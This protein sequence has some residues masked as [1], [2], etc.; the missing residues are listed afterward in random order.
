MR[1][2]TVALDDA[3]FNRLI[4]YVV[5]NSKRKGSRLSVSRSA[6]ELISNG[7][8]NLSQRQEFEAR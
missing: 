2:I 1:K 6:S 5:D 4:D 8:A 3:V 7:L